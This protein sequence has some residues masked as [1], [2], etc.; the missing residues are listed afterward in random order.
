M[1]L[2]AFELNLELIR[3]YYF[4]MRPDFNMVT[5]IAFFCNHLHPVYSLICQGGILDLKPEALQA[6]LNITVTGGLVASQ[7]VE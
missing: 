7:E 6:A 4:I 2:I 3:K 5:E 1:L